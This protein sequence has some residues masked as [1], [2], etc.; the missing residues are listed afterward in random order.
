MRD[1]FDSHQ[2]KFKEME[3]IDVNTIIAIQDLTASRI[4]DC[5][6]SMQ[7]W[8]INHAQF[9]TT[10]NIVDEGMDIPRFLKNA[11]RAFVSKFEPIRMCS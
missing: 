1:I 11:I 2:M 10:L 7:S 6:R 3:E 9:L 8:L 5:E 4:C